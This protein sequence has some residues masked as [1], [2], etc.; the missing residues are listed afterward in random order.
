MKRIMLAAAVALLLF[1]NMMAAREIGSHQASQRQSISIVTL[2]QDMVSHD[3][4]NSQV[5][6]IAGQCGA[7]S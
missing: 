6:K 3:D 7:L 4:A 2:T 1:T 5:S